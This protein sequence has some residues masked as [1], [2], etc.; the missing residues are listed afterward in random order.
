[1]PDDIL[2]GMLPF[3]ASGAGASKTTQNVGNGVEMVD[4]G[5]ILQNQQRQFLNLLQIAN[6]KNRLRQ[7]PIELATKQLELEAK[8]KQL[9]IDTATKQANL[10]KLNNELA[11]APYDLVKKQADSILATNNVQMMDVKNMQLRAEANKAQWDATKA[12]REEFV[13]RA[14]SIIELTNRAPE[15]AKAFMQQTFGPG[16][17]LV[18]NKDGTYTAVTPGRKGIISQFHFNPKGLADPEK[19]ANLERANRD[20]FERNPEISGYST[21][22]QNWQAMQQNAKLGTGAGDMAML[23]NAVKIDNPGAAVREGQ[24]NAL[25][26]VQGISDLWKARY[27]RYIETGGKAGIFGSDEVRQ[28]FLEGQR[29]NVEKAR[30]NALEVGRQLF[31]AS[32]RGGTNP[33]NVVRPVGDIGRDELVPPDDPVLVKKYLG[34]KSMQPNISQ[35]PAPLPPGAPNSTPVKQAGYGGSFNPD[36]T[37]PAIP[38]STNQST[39]TSADDVGAKLN[40]ALNESIWGN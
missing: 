33:W 8:Q 38:G 20:S 29:A 36:S 31:G 19:I 26:N 10:Q 12:Q 3:G 32:D 1:M 11:Q 27:R 6:L 25:D 9:P 39:S 24:I 34:A 21:V 35:A 18:D 40:Q 5:G 14:N 7:A 2:T 4:L 15:L 17:D 22:S 13:N 37:A 28:N 23:F 30:E 16:S